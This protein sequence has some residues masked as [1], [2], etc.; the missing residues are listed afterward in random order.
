MDERVSSIPNAFYDLIVFVT[1]SILLVTGV[2]IG[3][4]G[5]DWIGDLEAPGNLNTLVPVALLAVFGSYEYGRIAET[6][7]AHV[8]Q[9]PLGRLAKLGILR[10]TDFLALH[11]YAY[12]QLGLPDAADGRPADKWVLYMFAFS[13]HAGIGGD[14]LKRYA[15]EKLSRSSAFTYALLFLASNIVG[16]LYLI[17]AVDLPAGKWGFGGWC[18]TLGSSLLVL[19]TYVEYYRRNCWNYDLLMKVIPV[20]LNFDNSG[21]STQHR[22]ED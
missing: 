1:P 12:E 11:P 16:G 13:R 6:W 20:L 19:A 17:R 14:L 8:V 3:V 21:D 15:W 22:V 9:K 10:N 5:V 7:S 18:F 4:S 2:S